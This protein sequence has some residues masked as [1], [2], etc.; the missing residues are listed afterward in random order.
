MSCEVPEGWEIAQLGNIAEVRTGG[1]PSRSNASYWGGDI[2]WMASGEIHQRYVF[3]TA[4]KITALALQESNARILPIGSVMVALNGQGKTRG[5]AA[6]LRRE[7]ACNQSLA[8]IIP[9]EPNIPDYFLFLFESMYSNL[10][11]L[12]GDDARNGLNLGILRS[13][14]VVLPP[15]NEQ[16]RIAEILSSVD[17][18]IA[19]TQAVIEQKRIIR[20]ELLSSRFPR[21]INQVFDAGN[22]VFKEWKFVPASSI[23]IDIIDCKNRTPPLA[24]Q[25]YAVVRTPNV[26]N[27]RFVASGLQF[28]DEDSF[29]EWTSRGLP[30]AGD[31]LF[32]RE[33]PYGEVCLAPNMSFCLGQRMMLLRANLKEIVP[34]YLLYSLQSAILK[35]EMFRRAGG[36]TVGHLRVKDVRNL[37]IPLA[38]MD[39]QLLIIKMFQS[40]DQSLDDNLGSLSSLKTLKAA[41]MSDLLTGRKRVTDTLPLAAE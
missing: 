32:T 10:R 12:T 26:R 24:E 27:G 19:A 22:T 36:S 29:N 2:E 37:P 30:Q 1:T 28:T 17:E 38:P 7:M 20:R 11:N 39:Q 41:L 8:A 13:L 23:C 35:K 9:Q 40:L 33:A 5:K 14:T 34:E 6:I 3:Q 15:P 4:E 31:V 16:R 18:A 25:G 21:E